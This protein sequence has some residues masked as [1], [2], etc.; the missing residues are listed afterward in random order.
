[1]GYLERPLSYVPLLPLLIALAAGIIAARFLAED[2]WIWIVAVVLLALAALII[3]RRWIGVLLTAVAVG[4]LCSSVDST[5]NTV[6]AP[7]SGTHYAGGRV[8]KVGRRSVSRSMVVELDRPYSGRCYLIVADPSPDIGI[9]DHI[10]F[11]AVFSS[12]DMSRDIDGDNDLSQFYYLNHIGS[13][14]FALHDSVSVVG[15][16]TGLLARLGRYRRHLVDRLT[17]SGLS[18]E[19]QSFLAALMLGDDSLLE[20]DVRP[21]FAAAGLAHVL[22][23][24]GMHVAVIA[25]ILSVMLFPLS[26]IGWRRGRWILI[27]ALLWLYACL[28]GLSPTVTRAVIMFTMVLIARCIGRFNAS[29][30]ALCFSAI[31]ILVVMP[32]QLFAPGFQLSFMAV[33][34]LITI[35]GALPQV[36]IDNRLMR[37][38]YDY[39]VF[40]LSASVGTMLLAA[41]YFGQVPLLFL[42]T[43][44]PVSLILPFILVGGILVL[45]LDSVGISIGMLDT[46]VDIICR[47]IFGFVRWVSDIPGA[48]LS[49]VSLPAW[50][51]WAGYAVILL[52]V[53]A[54]YFRRYVLAV[55]GVALAVIVV[56][57]V[58]FSRETDDVLF[59]GRNRDA[60]D[61]IFTGGGEG[62]IVSSAPASFVGREIDR[63]MSRYSGFM[64]SRGI[65]TLVPVDLS[66]SGTNTVISFGGKRIVMINSDDMPV[67]DGHADYVVVCRG[68][69][70]D[71]VTLA[72]SVEC[73]SVL[74][75]TDING[76]RCRRYLEELQEAGVP[77]RSLSGGYG[78]VLRSIR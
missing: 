64:M 53:A 33:L 75:G 27:I 39:V 20:S 14:A 48:S 2:I 21:G 8:V 55:S 9:G 30:N 47:W 72:G 52:M 38:L 62:Y 58:S 67:C 26:F 6:S 70:G 5:L 74:L 56:S 68:F 11:T 29:A 7:D 76:V 31:V 40:T 35:P 73:D 32:R 71:V 51:I 77:S 42:F 15:A 59:I 12:L 24:S 66:A 3:G 54:I 63:A 44:L 50:S 23:L 78:L 28:T 60:T 45:L 4:S 34:A 10:G 18:D 43:N 61:I 22:A 69:R 17:C 16:D 57:L 37:W 13:R 36:R 19:S 41:Y 49:G 1:M 46:A 25:A 65:D